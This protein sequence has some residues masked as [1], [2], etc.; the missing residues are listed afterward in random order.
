MGSHIVTISIHFPFPVM[1]IAMECI[2][3]I[4]YFAYR[5]ARKKSVIFANSSIEIVARKTRRKKGASKRIYVARA[6]RWSV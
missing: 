5:A 6:T 1:I 2:N 4:G 3:S